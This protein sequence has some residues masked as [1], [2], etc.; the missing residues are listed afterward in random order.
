MN[1][2]ERF[3]AIKS[4]RSQLS[5]KKIRLEERLRTEKEK[6][7]E[8]LKEISAKGYDPKNLF[9]IKQ[10]KQEELKASLKN[11]EEKLQ[12]IS[13]NLNAVEA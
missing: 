6:L 13:E 4:K 11:L 9:A 5:D 8:L 2:V 7:E 1:E 10:K 12:E 3:Q